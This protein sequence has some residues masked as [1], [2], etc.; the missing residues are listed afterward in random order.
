[1][2][3]KGFVQC[4]SLA[5]VFRAWQDEC[6]ALKLEKGEAWVR[7]LRKTRKVSTEGSTP[8][9]KMKG[10]AKGVIVC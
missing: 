8:E 9:R 6:N 2:M 7:G 5:Q 10:E 1:M 3:G 4:H